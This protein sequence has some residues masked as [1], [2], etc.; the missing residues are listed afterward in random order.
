MYSCAKQG[1]I[2]ASTTGIALLTPLPAMGVAGVRWK[3]KRWYVVVVVANATLA[4]KL[5]REKTPE[6]P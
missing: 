4:T 6:K 3:L 5:L 1:S 2:V